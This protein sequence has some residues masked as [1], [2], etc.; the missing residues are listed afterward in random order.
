MAGAETAAATVFAMTA[1]LAGLVLVALL[2]WLSFALVIA[3]IVVAVVTRD[4]RLRLHR[5]EAGLL[6]EM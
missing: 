4:E 5:Y 1:L 2:V 3:C 6:P